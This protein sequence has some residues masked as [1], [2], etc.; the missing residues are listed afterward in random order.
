LFALRFLSS[1]SDKENQMK[2]NRNVGISLLALFVSLVPGAAPAPA[3]APA[4][5]QKPAD[6]KPVAA[7]AKTQPA[8]KSAR[9]MADGTQ[10]GIKVHGDWTIVIRNQDGSVAARH[11]FHNALTNF[12]LL[13]TILAH[14]G[15]AGSWGILVDGGPTGP[16]FGRGIPLAC[17][18]AETGNAV[19]NNAEMK[20]SVNG[21]TLLMVGSVK[22]QN[23]SQ[24]TAVSTGFT[25]CPP[26]Q[27]PSIG[28]GG[29]PTG[30]TAKD[31]TSLNINVGADQTM[32]ITV[33]ISFSSGT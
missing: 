29:S 20:V 1:D 10:E 28:C 12:T 23:A 3:Q 18:L 7:A 16:C 11:E 24:I 15:S 8:A 9:G 13:P 17:Q 32:D 30:F 27:P 25:V 31:V 5:R 21:T 19:A 22:A 26:S 6:V 14:G 33:R 4:T 2:A